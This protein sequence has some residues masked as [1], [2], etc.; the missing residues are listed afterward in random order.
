MISPPLCY[1]HL[2]FQEGLCNDQSINP[3]PINQSKVSS[4]QRESFTTKKA[5]FS[6]NDAD[7]VTSLATECFYFPLW[8]FQ[9]SCLSRKSKN[10]LLFELVAVQHNVNGCKTSATV[11]KVSK[12][13]ECVHAASVVNRREGAGAA[14]QTRL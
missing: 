11:E 6:Q 14:P 1:E 12:I 2:S 8:T 10:A 9:R 4:D 13:Q 5:A 7:H 3:N